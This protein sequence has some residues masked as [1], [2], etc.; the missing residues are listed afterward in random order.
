MKANTG[1]NKGGRPKREVSSFPADWE[2]TILTMGKSGASRAE[3][4]AYL[5]LDNETMTAMEKRDLKFSAVIKKFTRNSQAWWEKH[6]RTQL[7]Q[8][9]FNAVLWYMNMKN[10]FGW[11]DK[12]EMEVKPTQEIAVKFTIPKAK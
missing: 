12:S 5:D 1:K 9:G 11:K 3:I 7:E 4:Q 8:K 10:R 6:G 2:D